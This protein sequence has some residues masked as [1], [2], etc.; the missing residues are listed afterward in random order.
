MFADARPDDEEGRIRALERLQAL[1]TPE[2]P[3]FEKIV[4]LIRQVLQ[5]P[6]CAISLIDRQRQW[7]KARSGL[8]SPQTERRHSICTHTIQQNVPF[9]VQDTLADDRF[10]ELPSVTGDPF[11]RSYVGI[12]LRMPDGYNVGSLCIMDSQPRAFSEREISILDNFSKI[13]IDEL[14]LRQIACSD[15]LTGTMTRRAWLEV[16]GKEVDRA[17]RYERPLA[18][19]LFDIDRFKAV[20]DRYGHP[21]GDVVIRTFAEV[22]S[23]AIRQSDMLGRLGGEEFAL[24]LPETEPDSAIQLADRLRATFGNLSIDV[25]TRIA[26]TMS[27]GIANRTSGADTLDILIDRADKALYLAKHGG[28]N[29]IVDFDDLPRATDAA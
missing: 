3:E 28:R 7:F 24:L 18:L 23:S 19:A 22:C 14:E 4:G 13:V 11:V 21:A 27:G 2:E 12:P 10:S 16:A 15:V 9:V 29:Q 20:N 8:V 17:R 6:M 26:C 1:D 25:G 5:V